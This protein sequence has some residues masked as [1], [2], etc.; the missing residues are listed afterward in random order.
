MGLWQ[1]SWSRCTCCKSMR[2]RWIGAGYHCSSVC[3]LWGGTSH[4]WWMSCH[5]NIDTLRYGFRGCGGSIYCNR[6][7]RATRVMVNCR[8]GWWAGKACQSRHK[9]PIQGV[10]IIWPFLITSYGRKSMRWGRSHQVQRHNST[11]YCRHNNCH[12]SQRTDTPHIQSTLEVPR[13]E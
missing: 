10:V 7:S 5:W 13:K 4:F 11:W 3:H 6:R 12:C 9:S 1:W 2:G 8:G